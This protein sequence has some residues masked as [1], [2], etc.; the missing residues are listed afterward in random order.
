MHTEPDNHLSRVLAEW[1]A[2][3]PPPGLSAGV[4]ARVD[5][6][7]PSWLENAWLFRAATVLTVALW[8]AVVLA[9]G[10]P[11]IGVASESLTVALARAGGAR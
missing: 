3:E 4:W 2:P 1:Q 11:A 8:V 9:P 7:R 6:R 5:A 10:R